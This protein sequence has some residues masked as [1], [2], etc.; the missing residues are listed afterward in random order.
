MSKSR[1]K[2]KI[3]SKKKRKRENINDV[4]NQKK[5]K[6]NPQKKAI[7]PLTFAMLKSSSK[8]EVQVRPKKKKERER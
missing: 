4:P 2:F 8:F 6:G 1:S 5:K 3:I 7:H